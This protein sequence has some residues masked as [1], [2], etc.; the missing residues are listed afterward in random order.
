MLTELMLAKRAISPAEV[1]GYESAEFTH[2]AVAAFIASGMADVGI[3]VQTAAHRFGLHFIP[4][5]RE[6]YF[7]ALD[8]AA[9]ER[10]P[11]PQ[12]LDLLRSPAYRSAVAALVGY[13]AGETGRVLA[14]QEAFGG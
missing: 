7:L 2:A 10:P 9:A 6:R 4:L 5:V 13:E 1:L 12:V 8:L 11:M 3:G 14:V